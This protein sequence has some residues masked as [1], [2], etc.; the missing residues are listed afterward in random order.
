[1]KEEFIL[2]TFLKKS[3]LVILCKTQVM[4]RRRVGVVLL[5]VYHEALF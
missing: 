3:V 1:M 5:I 2:Q 4:K